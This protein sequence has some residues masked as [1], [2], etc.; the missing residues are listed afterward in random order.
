MA[1]SKKIIGFL[2]VEVMDKSEREYQVECAEFLH[3]MVAN[4]FAYKLS[5]MRIPPASSPYVGQVGIN[6]QVPALWKKGNQI[7]GSA[8]DIQNTLAHLRTNVLVYQYSGSIIS[9]DELVVEL[10]EERTIKNWPDTLEHKIKTL[11]VRCNPASC[12]LVAVQVLQ[13]GQRRFIM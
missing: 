12:T 9:S 7:T 11:D 10:I 2:I 4:A 3:V 5:P 8:T 13:T 6:S 1:Q